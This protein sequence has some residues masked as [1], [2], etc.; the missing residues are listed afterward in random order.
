MGENG[1]NVE[2][3]YLINMDKDNFFS[4]EWLE[5]AL[6]C[7]QRQL[8]NCS[9]AFRGT[10]LGGQAAQASGEAGLTAL[11]DPNVLVERLKG[12]EICTHW[13]ANER[14]NYGRIGLPALLFH[15]M[16]GYDEEMAPMGVQDTDLIHRC[17]MLGQVRHIT[18]EST[19]FSVPNKPA[20]ATKAMA[21][22]KTRNAGWDEDV[23][24]KVAF[25]DSPMTWKQMTV[26]NR[27]LAKKRTDKGVWQVN[28]ELYRIGVPCFR[29]RFHST[30][31]EA[32]TT[33][34]PG[35]DITSAPSVP[36]PV[37]ELQPAP[38][39]PDV[40]AQAAASTA[41]AGMTAPAAKAAT[42]PEDAAAKAG[43]TARAAPALKKV[44]IGEPQAKAAPQVAR[45]TTVPQDRLHIEV[46][47]FG[48]RTL[49]Q[50]F[51]SRAAQEMRDTMWPRT[52]QSTQ[53]DLRNTLDP[54]V[55]A[56]ALSGLYPT[57]FERV[58]CINCRGLHGEMG[59][60]CGMHP[61]LLGEYLDRSNA[62]ALR[63]IMTEIRDEVLPL[64]HERTLLAFWCNAGEHRSVAMCLVTKQW[65]ERALH[66]HIKMTHH[67]QALWSRRSC[68]GCREC[69][70]QTDTPA[71]RDATEAYMQ[72]WISDTG[73]ALP[74]LHSEAGMT[75]HTH[76]GA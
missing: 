34:Q 75:A 4:A 9:V 64:S 45:F 63:N 54:T 66:I 42:P 49:A 56:R 37:V 46:C 33:A 36:R 17:E 13:D 24:F 10:G 21:T 28:T 6:Q 29:V 39:A 30:L 74:E 47:S 12:Q 2:E 62:R 72:R 50:C 31:G 18:D 32:G 8:R 3:T 35:T 69:D 1:Y 38:S 70:P 27:K 16:G 43:M 48:T 65:L 20:D 22:K 11:V 61:T 73:L 60:H 55:A 14:G 15:M 57:E 71:R 19:G 58:H 7:A 59:Q 53:G 51:A 26:H 52:R 67:C 5:D 44:R 25:C 41:K 68:G 23:V 76:C 40:P